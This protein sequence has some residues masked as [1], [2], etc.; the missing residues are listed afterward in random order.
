MGTT[1][2]KNHG[3]QSKDASGGAVT[4]QVGQSFPL[5]PFLAG[6]C[7]C[8]TVDVACKFAL[9]LRVPAVAVAVG[10]CSFDV[11]FVWLLPMRVM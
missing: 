9:M 8:R 2:S 11:A 7:K 10:V 1:A 3:A 4:Q 6:G 5:V